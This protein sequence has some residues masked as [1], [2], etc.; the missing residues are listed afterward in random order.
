MRLELLEKINP[1]V[2]AI[3]LIICCFIMAAGGTWQ[4]NAAVIIMV[5]AS[6]LVASKCSIRAMLMLYIPLVL[7][8]GLIFLSSLLSKDV[9]SAGHSV[10]DMT[11]FDTAL[12]LGTRILSYA[13]IGVI[14]GL[15]TTNKGFAMSLMQQLKLAPKFAYGV[16]A[17]L[18]LVPTLRREWDEV[19]LA[20]AVR[21]K[22]TGIFGF[23][24][25]FNTLVNGIRWSENIAMA[26]ESKGFDGDEKRSF[27]V[28]TPL[29]ARDWIFS[30][31]CIG[32]M[33]LCFIF[34]R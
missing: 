34:L 30:A 2:K 17:A 11:T 6:L 27:Y 21:G 32:A 33:I 1:T 28:T 25:L 20:Y 14:F 12:L 15:T 22:S 10:S 18:Y 5:I 19:N 31:V 23:K 7:L 9:A 16:L 4:I 3:V 24:P 8:G 13:S 29:G 26:M